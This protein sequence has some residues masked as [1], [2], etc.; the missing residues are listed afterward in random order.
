MTM[1]ADITAHQPKGIPPAAS[2]AGRRA[3]TGIIAGR[4]WGGPGLEVGPGQGPAG[5]GVGGALMEALRF[6]WA[7]QGTPCRRPLAAAL[8]DLVP[9]LRRLMIWRLMT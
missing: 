9:R 1:T 2:S 3:G 8:P 5:T 4:P 7:V 6:C